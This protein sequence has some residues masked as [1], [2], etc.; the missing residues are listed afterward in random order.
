[1]ITNKYKFLGLIALLFSLNSC[2]LFLGVRKKT[3]I[4]VEPLITKEIQDSSL[5]RLLLT[6]N[7]LD[8]SIL[9]LEY[10]YYVK[11]DSIWKDSVNQIIGEFFYSTT[12]DYEVSKN[13]KYNLSNEF[14][15]SCLDKFYKDAQTD[16]LNSE[17]PVL[18]SYEASS[19]IS[20]EY[21]NFI[22]I[23]KSVYA[24]TGGAHGNSY[25]E[26]IHIDKLTGRKL[27]LSDFITN[28]K[29]FTTIAEQFFRE[30]IGV[31]EDENLYELGYI[32]P[33]NKFYCND[34]FYIEDGEF[35]FL[36]NTYEI[37]TYAEG[38]I[39]FTVPFDSVKHLIKMD[40][41]KN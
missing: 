9:I 22:T 7:K 37:A 11:N 28:V 17:Y 25:Q 26:S 14:F 39:E 13:K 31:G 33:E 12:V 4:V 41:S 40:L 24:F 30:A 23:F 3:K 15:V 20:N 32:F 1:M 27:K 2:F 21:K 18:W 8:T 36:Y 5:N 10:Q 34:N 29:E 38:Q 16:Y 35:H 6:E 19:E